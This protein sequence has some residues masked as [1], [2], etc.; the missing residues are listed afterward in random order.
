MLPAECAA[1]LDVPALDDEW[2]FDLAARSQ[3]EE[4]A[5]DGRGGDDFED[6]L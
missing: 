4:A 3:E 2:L 1:G 5:Q 6:E